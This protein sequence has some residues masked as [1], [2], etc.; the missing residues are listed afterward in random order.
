LLERAI[1]FSGQVDYRIEPAFATHPIWAGFTQPSFVVNSASNLGVTR[2]GPGIK[3]VATSE[4][5]LD[6]VAILELPDVGRVV[7]LA[8]SG[9]YGPFG[10]S[11]PNIR[12]LLANSVRW[13]TR[14]Q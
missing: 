5:V 6:P 13:T 8:H 4:A 2:L 10:W 11:N 14:Q 3:R 7:H 9:N 12:K 1:A